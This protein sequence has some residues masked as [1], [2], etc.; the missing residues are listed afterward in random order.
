MKQKQTNIVSEGTQ[1]TVRNVQTEEILTYAL[2]SPERADP[3][4]GIISTTSPLAQGILGRK[5]G[6]I[7]S[8]PVKDGSITVEIL[9]IE[10]A[11]SQ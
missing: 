5:A 3:S 11:G 7:A 6:E 1:V 4:A 8:F 9:N 2:A 10:P